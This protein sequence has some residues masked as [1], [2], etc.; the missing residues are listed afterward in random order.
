MKS[1]GCGNGILSAYGMALADVVHEAQEPCAK[2][3]SQENFH[4]FD[5]HLRYLEEECRGE[6]GKNRASPMTT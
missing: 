2:I 4:Y 3:Y 1:L 5:Q 6:L